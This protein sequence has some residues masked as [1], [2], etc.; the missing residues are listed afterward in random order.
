M[1]TS[2]VVKVD[3]GKAPIDRDWETIQIRWLYTIVFHLS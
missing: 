1:E 3:V 2:G